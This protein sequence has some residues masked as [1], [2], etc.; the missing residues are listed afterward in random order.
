VGRSTGTMARHTWLGLAALAAVGGLTLAAGVAP[1]VL[2][3]GLAAKAAARHFEALP[4]VA[5]R[6]PSAASS[7]LRCGAGP[8]AAPAVAA[9]RALCTPPAWLP[10]AA[11]NARATAK[12]VSRCV[13]IT[14]I[15]ARVRVVGEPG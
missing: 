2:G 14:R 5:I 10:H 9:S 8:G 1:V 12:D 4:A 13:F 7:T 6:L 15:V 11:T 3:V